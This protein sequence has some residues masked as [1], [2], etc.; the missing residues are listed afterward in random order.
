MTNVR[1]FRGRVET[2]RAGQC[3]DPQTAAA[4]CRPRGHDD[5]DGISIFGFNAD[6][7]DTSYS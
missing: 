5:K 3:V 6:L 4:K 7:A 1:R 2:R